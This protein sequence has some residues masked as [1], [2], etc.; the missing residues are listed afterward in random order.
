MNTT[1][2]HGQN[3]NIYNNAIIPS[4][5]W[6]QCHQNKLLTEYN[7]NNRKSNGLRCN[8]KSCQSI[9][10]KRY[11]ENIKQINANKIVNEN[12]VKICFKCKQ[13]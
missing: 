3:V 4:K 12:N 10:N 11:R 9:I 1:I 7:K 13:S 2:N 6:S 8:C 5:V